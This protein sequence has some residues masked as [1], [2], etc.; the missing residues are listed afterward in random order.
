VTTQISRN[1]DE[2]CITVIQ[3][4][5][6]EQDSQCLVNRRR[7]RASNTAQL[8][9]TE[10]RILRSLRRASKP[11]AAVRWTCVLMVKSASS[12]NIKI[13]HTTRWADEVSADPKWNTRQLRLQLHLQLQLDT[14]RQTTNS[15][16]CSFYMYK[17]V[18]Y[19][20]ACTQCTK[21]SC[22]VVP[23]FS[24]VTSQNIHDRLQKVLVTLCQNQIQTQIKVV[25]DL[26]LVVQPVDRVCV[27]WTA[28]NLSAESAVPSD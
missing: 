17:S 26:Q 11:P 13:T 14:T 25:N 4:T 15:T 2:S 8:A 23:L 28:G 27:C 22:Y 5:H 21:S 1:S 12:K 18:H 20:R 6:N 19:V 16:Y 9:Q 7:D 24:W 10:R 3:A